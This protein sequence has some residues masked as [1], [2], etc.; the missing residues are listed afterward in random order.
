LNKVEWVDF[1]NDKETNPSKCAERMI[2][3][4]IS[5]F[6]NNSFGKIHAITQSPRSIRNMGLLQIEWVKI[7]LKISNGPLF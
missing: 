2:P 7:T 6:K 3:D 5:F 1:I 4:F